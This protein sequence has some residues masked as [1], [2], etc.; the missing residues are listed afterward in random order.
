MPPVFTDRNDPKLINMI[1]SGAVGVLP[2]DTV[3]GVVAAADNPVAVA[4]LYELKNRE[5][6]P[7]TTIASS[8]QQLQALGLDAVSLKQ[9]SR[10]WPAP[11]SIV[12]PQGQKLA[13]LHQGTGESPFRVVADQPT[14][15]FLEKTGPLVTSSANRPT[16]PPATNLRQAQDYFGDRVDYYVDGGETGERPPSTIA[17][18]QPDGR[19]RIFRQ[20]AAVIDP[21]DRA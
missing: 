17:G 3:Y 9:A 10:F 21:K 7:G 15:E 13:Y 8:V 18:L 20:G 19:L 5:R 12:L 4:K 6:K 16:E 14:R 2:T 11:L 1:R